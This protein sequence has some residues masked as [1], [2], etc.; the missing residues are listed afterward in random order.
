MTQ[1]TNCKKC[2]VFTVTD[3]RILNKKYYL[4]VNCIEAHYFIKL[5]K[6]GLIKII[7]I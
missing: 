7:N 6:T 3:G 5:L 2:N 1:I 4:K